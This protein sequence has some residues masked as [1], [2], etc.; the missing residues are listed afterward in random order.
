MPHADT[1]LRLLMLTIWVLAAGPLLVFG[2]DSSDPIEMLKSMYD[3]VP[4]HLGPFKVIPQLYIS[5]MG[6]DSNVY[7]TSVNPVKDFTFT[8]GPAGTFLLRLGHRA[9]FSFY[10]SPRYVFYRKEAQQ[11]GW[12]NALTLDQYAAMNRVLIKFT[13]SLLISH[14]RISSEIDFPARVQ[15]GSGQGTIL[16]QT[17]RRTSIQLRASVA[18]FK[19]TEVDPREAQLYLLDRW[20]STSAITIFYQLFPKTKLFAEAEARGYDFT[21][22][23]SGRDTRSFGLYSGLE[24]SPDA[25]MRGRIRM[26]YKDFKPTNPG[27]KPFSG[28][29]GD[30]SVSRQLRDRYIVR[31]LYTR[32]A[33][34]SA[35]LDTPYY[36]EERAGGGGSVYFFR[37]FRF[38][39]DYSIG[40]NS[41][42]S[43]FS[44]T[45][46]RDTFKIH[47]A[48]AI[49]R[50]RDRW[51]L[52]LTYT[53]FSR[54]SNIVGAD[55]DRSY[56]GIH[57]AYNDKRSR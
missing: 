46:R 28:I 20:E 49:H 40:S 22:P 38:D 47:T 26:G 33:Y 35:W 56:W 7:G 52:G 18:E 34:F 24:F 17:A 21:D 23:A 41:Y 31:G 55:E 44:T 27:A 36:I 48:R 57:V 1:C 42:P 51:E 4:M 6:M 13:E 16:W 15:V 19:Y 5:N 11:R 10:E 29:A 43:Y 8:S 9:L 2:A 53:D 45:D 50:F 32:D 37:N 39:Y 12:N 54:R 30:I 3:E 25:A 14:E